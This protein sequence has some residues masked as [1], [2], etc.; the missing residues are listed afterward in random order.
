MPLFQP[1]NLLSCCIP[2]KCHHYS[3]YPNLVL[4]QLCTSLLSYSLSPPSNSF[5]ASPHGTPVF[6]CTPCHPLTLSPSTPLTNLC[7][8]NIPSPLNLSLVTSIAYILPQP[9]LTSLTSNL[10]GFNSLFNTSKISFSASSKWEGAVRT[11][12]VRAASE[13]IPASPCPIVPCI[14]DGEE[15]L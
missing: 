8:F 14:E 13:G 6:I 7:C 12:F 10:C 9:P 5:L 15:E 4:V 11:S 1:S 3:T 2:S